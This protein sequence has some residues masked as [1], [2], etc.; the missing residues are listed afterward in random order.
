ME[1]KYCPNCKAKINGNFC[2][3]CGAKGVEKTEIQG[4]VK[5][6]R[7]EKQLSEVISY[8]EVKE[9]IKGFHKFS[10]KSISAEEFL[11]RFDVLFSPTLGLSLK[12]VGNIAMPIYKKMGV[13]TGKSKTIQIDK[14][15][16]EIFVKVLCSLIKNNLP[17]L[18]YQESEN[19]ILILAEIPSS[20]KTF[21]GDLAISIESLPSITNLTVKAT[22]PGQIYDWGE[23]KSILKSIFLDIEEIE[24][25]F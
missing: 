19:G 22:I 2:S 18:E 13:K 25:N 23:C 6:W 11:E 16:Q 7:T 4:S 21:G 17:V 24:L 5:T 20:I 8:P 12:S 3:E 1:T 15:S 14:S 10:K 9:F